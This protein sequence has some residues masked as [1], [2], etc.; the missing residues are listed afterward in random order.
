MIFSEDL[1]NLNFFIKNLTTHPGVY[2]MYDKERNILYIGKAKNLYKRVNSYFNRSIKDQKTK[3]M[4]TQISYI[5]VTITPSE[6]DAFIL[7][8]DL[9][10]KHRPKYNIV[11]K[12]D[13]NY[14]YLL[15]SDHPFP[16]L[17]FC[18]GN[19]SK[20]GTLFGPYI[21]LSSLK[22]TLQVL[23]RA[24]LIRQ[25]NDREFNSRSQPCLQY[26]I[27]R[28]SAPC[29]K[30]ISQKSYGVQIELLKKFMGDQSSSVLEEILHQMNDASKIENFEMAKN[31]RDKFTL[32]TKI[33]PQKN[34]LNHTVNDN[35]HLHA[36]GMFYQ[37]LKVCITL[38]N[39]RHNKV[40]ND[41]HWFVDKK[42]KT[43]REILE[44]LLSYYYLS[45]FHGFWP[46]KIILPSCLSIKKGLLHI[47][48]KKASCPIKWITTPS[49]IDLKWQQLA[50]INAQQKLE[51]NLKSENYIAARF[52]KLADWLNISEIKS[53]E[54][55]DVSH[56]QGEATV[57]S[58]VVFDQNGACKSA[59][60]QYSIKNIIP[61]D[62]YA[63]IS[64]V[65]EQRIIFGEKTKNIPDVMILDGG[66]G[67][68][69]KAEEILVKFNQQN[70]IQLLSLS[71]GKS[72]IN[73][74]EKVFRG[75]D[76]NIYSFLESNVVFL[77]LRHIR[78]EAHNFALKGHRKKISKIKMDSVLD[79]IKGIGKKRR[80][81][82]L[83]HFGG[84]KELTQASI[85]EISKVKG[86]G[87]YVATCIWNSLH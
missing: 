66:K 82:L 35:K 8:S 65:V 42:D 44:S 7:E 25:C 59:Y 78:D 20:S 30:K 57:A 75:F 24:F 70:N 58:C 3:I 23:Q 51:M 79:S 63:A 29:V 85:D 67:Q 11:F 87:L 62:D 40:V 73:G 33:Q 68:I 32:L 2:R 52:K 60:R 61:G 28:C 39:V 56:H 27:K 77:F 86:I 26:Q 31:L 72:R 45:T 76:K 43:L 46:H 81:E 74:K 69:K 5:E 48:A 12:D 22:K 15:L 36:F 1:F 41:Q 13:K 19:E 16:R 6:Y 47:I 53:I 55:F 18:R 17:S 4:V 10:K 49:F 21:S 84:W 38:I 71:K 64:Q 9:I 34:T 14:P 37:N 50:S 80:K 54:C 83:S